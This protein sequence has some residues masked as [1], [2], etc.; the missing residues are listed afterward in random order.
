M[1]IKKTMTDKAIEANQNN[2]KKGHGPI[3]PTLANQHAQKHS[4]QS[5][6][7]VFKNE[8]ERQEYEELLNDLLDEYQPVGRTAVEL[9]TKLAFILWKSERGNGLEMQELA[10]RGQAAAAI[11]RTLAENDSEQLP[12]FTAPDGSHS[13][14]QFGWECQELVVRTGTRNSEEE[15]EGLHQDRTGKIGHVQIGA[16]LNTSLDTLLRYQTALNRYLYRVI[17]ELRSMRRERH[18]ER[19]REEK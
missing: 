1:K 9:V 2:G 7:L 4:L 3:N 11:L 5:K 8:E 19:C 18:E 12:L 13:A 10:Y 15:N 6:H 16:R 14:V 17:G